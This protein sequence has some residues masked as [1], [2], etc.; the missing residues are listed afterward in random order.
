MMSEG[1]CQQNLNIDDVIADIWSSSDDESTK[2]SEEHVISGGKHSDAS[3]GRDGENE[4]K[5]E[6]P[7]QADGDSFYHDYSD[8]E[9]GDS[10]NS[11]SYSESENEDTDGEDGYN[12]DDEAVGKMLDWGGGQADEYSCEEEGQRGRNKKNVSSTAPAG[13]RR[14][15][16]INKTRL[17][18]NSCAHCNATREN[19]RSCDKQLSKDAMMLDLE[20]FCVS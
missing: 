16:L 10:V 5:E 4:K 11:N 8:D 7:P 17:A 20:H 19:V 1:V 12:S 2:S 18:T 3:C 6:G 9:D 13:L 15:V 14:P